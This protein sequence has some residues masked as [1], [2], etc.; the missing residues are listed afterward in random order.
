MTPSHTP[1][2]TPSKTATSTVTPTPAFIAVKIVFSEQGNPK[3]VTRMIRSSADPIEAALDEYF[4]GPNGLEQSSGVVV[5]LNGFT[6]YE[7]TEFN[8]GILRVYLEGSC[9]GNGTSGW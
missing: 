1:T 6:G 4:K 7:R 8:N 2:L 5:L 3:A 9:E